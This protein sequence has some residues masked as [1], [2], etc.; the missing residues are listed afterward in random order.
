MENVT[1]LC[2]LLCDKIIFLFLDS[3]GILNT[4]KKRYYVSHG[5]HRRCSFHFRYM[6]SL[7]YKFISPGAMVINVFAILQVFLVGLGIGS[8]FFGCF[9][10]NESRDLKRNYIFTEVNN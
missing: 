7:R 5:M 2:S 1:I 4:L 6:T 3:K 10:R 9:N 8:E